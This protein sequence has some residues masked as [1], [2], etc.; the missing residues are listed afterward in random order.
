MVTGENDLATDLNKSLAELEEMLKGISLEKPIDPHNEAEPEP[1]PTV[2]ENCPYCIKNGSFVRISPDKMSA[3]IYLHEPLAGEDFYSMDLVMQFLRENNV[4]RGYHKSNLAAIVKKHV[5]EREIL[6]AKGEQPKF[7]E[8]GHYEYLF[9]TSDKRKPTIREDGTV[10]YLSMSQLTNVNE[11]DRVAIYHHSVPSTDGFDVTG[12]ELTSKPVKDLPLL[13]GRGISN[14]KDPDVYIATVTGRID[15]VDGRVDIKDV[16]EV[17]GDV[18]LVTGKVEFFGDIYISGNVEAGVVIRASRNV[19]VAGV[20]EAATIY[21]GG[22]VVLARGMQG[23]QK[24]RITAKGN[25]SADFIEHAYVE[26][27][28]DVRSNSFINANVFAEGMVIAEGD[29]GI[30]LGG[31]VRGLKGV[32]AQKAGNDVETKTTIASGY[33]SDDYTRYI[34]AFTEEADYQKLLSETVEEMT[35]ILKEKRLGR[36]KTPAITEQKLSNLNVK[37]DEYFEALDKARTLKEDLGVVIEKG[38]GSAIVISDKVH[39]GVTICVEGSSLQ[40]PENTSFMR[41]KN[42]GG[43]IIPTVITVK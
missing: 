6:V 36:D 14:E 16:Y 32:N 28:G 5:Y 38:K 19:T 12:R 3:W 27:G 9:D 35:A 8:N 37:K 25:V 1:V 39:R 40:V 4:N 31:E 30:V 33:S 2:D 10:D 7:G 34:N 15:F 29:N 42:E 26:A 18:D 43:R 24:G 20:V 17:S 23:G 22:D 41:Y 21:A 11:G 13:K